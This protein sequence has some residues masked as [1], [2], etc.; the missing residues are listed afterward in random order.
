MVSYFETDGRKLYSKIDSFTHWL[1]ILI[2]EQDEVIRTVY[3]DDILYD[4][5]NLG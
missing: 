5:L 1:Q 3:D 4:E 2:D